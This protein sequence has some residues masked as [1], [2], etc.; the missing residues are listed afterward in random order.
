MTEAQPLRL[1]FRQGVQAGSGTWY[2]NLQFL[3][4]GGNAV[5]YLMLADGGPY[6]G[7]PFAVKIFENVPRPERR[8]S[9]FKEIEFLRECDHPGV[10]RIYDEGTYRDEYPFVVAEY[11]PSTLRDVI[12][13][14]SASMVEKLSFA[15]QLVSSL[16]YLDALDP[17]VI[18]RDIKPQ[19]IFIKGKSCVLGD[20]GLMKRLDG[21]PEND[22]SRFLKESVGLGM[23]FFYRTPD[24]VAYAR[25]ES[26]PTTK[27]DIF[28]LGL[29]LSELF[30][31]R[32]P[33]H[34]AEYDDP[35]SDVVLDSIA[36]IPGA[37]YE[38]IRDPISSMLQFNPGDRPALEDLLARWRDVFFHFAEIVNDV[39]GRV[40]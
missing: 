21:I 23:P 20:F 30:S 17:P 9:F 11:L 1:S 7:N 3:G 24:L 29:V 27:S 12:R 2:N 16:Q 40:F 26:Y 25:G 19:N 39:E 37:S 35:L 15:T 13:S 18:H 38:L 10:M 28:Q 5:T 22:S 31:G 33:Q 4:R 14:R 36:F 32:N 8:E 34:R 6:R